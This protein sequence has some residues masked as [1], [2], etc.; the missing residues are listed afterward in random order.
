M[1]DEDGAFIWLESNVPSWEEVV[2]DEM[3]KLK[4]EI[5]SVA[6]EILRHDAE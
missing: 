5:R 4:T 6:A 3:E 2:R 1:N